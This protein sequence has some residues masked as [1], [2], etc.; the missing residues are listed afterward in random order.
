[1]SRKNN[2]TRQRIQF[3]TGVPLSYGTKFN[4]PRPQSTRPLDVQQ[5]QGVRLRTPTSLP[6][7]SRTPLTAK[8]FALLQ[9]ARKRLSNSSYVPIPKSYIPVRN[10][11]LSLRMHNPARVWFC[12][13]RK[14]R[15]AVLFAM[16]K[17][18]RAGSS[19][20]RRGRYRRNASSQYGC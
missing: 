8:R 15:R 18:G 16:K 13:K 20:G 5:S 4:L 6:R 10:S 14:M 3:R 17:V 1:M 12:A 2:S 7:V 9:V 11:L 19:P